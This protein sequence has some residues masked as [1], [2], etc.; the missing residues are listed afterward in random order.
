MT[1]STT[2]VLGLG[3]SGRAVLEALSGRG[4]AARAVDDAPGAAARKCVDRLGVPLV[5]APRAGDWPGLLEGI[6]EVAMGPGIP[7]A[8]PCHGAARAAGVPVVDESDLAARWDDRPRCA[9]TGTNGKTTV[10]T[11]VVDMLE[12]SGI[13]AR[14]AG[15]TDTPLVAAID[16]VEAAAF[17]VEASSFRLAHAGAFR[18]S[19]AAWLNFAPDHLDVHADVAAYEAGWAWGRPWGRPR[20]GCSRAWPCRRTRWPTPAIRW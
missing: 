4:L 17:V 7:D 15:N 20:R 5:V 18:A 1:G 10:V 11:L 19:P 13:R 12:R 3:L 2:L 9:V 14:A 16:D 8:H 6:T